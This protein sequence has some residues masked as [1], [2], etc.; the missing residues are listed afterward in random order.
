MR[1]WDERCIFNDNVQLAHSTISQRDHN[2]SNIIEDNLK[3]GTQLSRNGVI[4]A[5]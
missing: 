1:K 3:C 2:L 5:A 4:I